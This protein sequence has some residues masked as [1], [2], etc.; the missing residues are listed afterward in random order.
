VRDGTLIVVKGHRSR[1]KH[2]VHERR[3]KISDPHHVPSRRVRELPGRWDWYGFGTS[4]GSQEA[5]G[6][7]RDDDL[8]KPDLS[9][10]Y[11]ERGA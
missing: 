3:H 5:R 8:L 9:T 10:C 2:T 1:V 11:S 4:A 6:R 7:Y